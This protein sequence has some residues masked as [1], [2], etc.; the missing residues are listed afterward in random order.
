MKLFFIGVLLICSTAIKAEQKDNLFPADFSAVFELYKSGMAVAE[1]E[2]RLHSQQQI[3]FQSTTTLKGLASLFSNDKIVEE[4]QFEI[5]TPASVQLKHYQFKQTGDKNKNIHSVVNWHQQNIKTTIDEQPVITSSFTQIIWDKHSVLL[6]LMSQ[7]NDQKKTLSFNTLDQGKIKQYNFSFIGTKEIE[8]DDDEWKQTSI[9][10][11][12][13]N[14]KKIIFYL[15]PNDHYIPLK[16]EEY[17]NQ[18]LRATLWLKELNW[19]E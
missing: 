15:D 3:N 17:K 18:R 16:I 8:L 5:T 11:R 12:E 4:S 10:Q 1:T 7:A 14:S 19:Y 13:N 9:W 6:A 2:Y